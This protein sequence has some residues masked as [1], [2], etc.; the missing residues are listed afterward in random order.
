MRPSPQSPS[1]PVVRRGLAGCERTVDIVVSVYN[2]EASLPFFH[3]EATRVVRL[4]AAGGVSARILYVDDGSL[5]CSA[6]ILDGFAASDGVEV[7]HLSRNFG[8]EAAMLAGLDHA[9]ADH[10]IFLD[11]DLQHPPAEIPGALARASEGFDIVLMRRETNTDEGRLRRGVNSIFYSLL[12]SIGPLPVEE[13]VSDFFLLSRPV[14]D[15]LKREFRER[16]RFLRGFVQWVGFRKTVLPYKASSRVAGVSKYP[17]WRLLKLARDAVIS[18][19]SAPLRA[20]LIAAAAMLFVSVGVGL[21]SIVGWMIGSPPSGYTTLI[22]FVTVVA[23]VQFGLLAIQGEY[24]A[25]LVDEAKGRPLYL[26]ARHTSDADA[27][28]REAA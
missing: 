12:N 9:T 1:H 20:A 2:E 15:V 24:I 4:L 3:A 22:L 11:G 17:S 19:S 27:R 10:V 26:V 28:E 7:V 14:V 25:Q 21:V 5:D 8:H 23:A 13:N 16:T 18:F 6:A